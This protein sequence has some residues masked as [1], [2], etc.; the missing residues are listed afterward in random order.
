MGKKNN[1]NKNKNNGLYEMYSETL[2]GVASSVKAVAM[3]NHDE[4]VS[5]SVCSFDEQVVLPK[6]VRQDI[7]DVLKRH[8]EMAKPYLSMI[9]KTL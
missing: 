6:D 9:A 2:N 1:K 3:L 4:T 7:I 5:I 8:V